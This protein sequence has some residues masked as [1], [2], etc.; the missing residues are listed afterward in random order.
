MYR[1]ISFDGGGVRGVYTVKLLEMLAKEITVLK[2]VHLLTGTSTGALIALGLGLGYSPKDLLELYKHIAP[3][4]FSG[5]K[6]GEDKARYESAHLRDFLLQHVFTSNPTLADVSYPI[7]IPVFKLYDQNTKSW[8]P[9]YFHNFDRVKAQ[10]YTVVDVALAA[11]A[12]PVFFPS[13]QGYI[14]GGVFAANPSMVG[15]CQALSLDPRKPCLEDVWLF[16]LGTLWQS[17]GIEHDVNWGSAGWM[18]KEFS[19]PLLTLMTDGAIDVPH[20]QC[21]QLLGYRYHRL[22][23]VAEQ[24]IAIDAA[25]AMPTLIA[26]AERVPEDYPLLWEQTLLWLKEFVGEDMGSVRKENAS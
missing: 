3:L 26:L 1:I 15:L 2:H 5:S 6:K 11:S 19:D 8:K 7:V 17:I 23:T 25:H 13:Y 24:P 21:E 9:T 20:E 16:S 4:I 18:S 12:A 14:D 22:N 10:Q